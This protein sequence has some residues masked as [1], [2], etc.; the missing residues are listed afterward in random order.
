M[1]GMTLESGKHLGVSRNAPKIIIIISKF[2]LIS[3]PLD[4][5]STTPLTTKY[6]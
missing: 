1:V 6:G 2:T 3:S 4:M 5:E